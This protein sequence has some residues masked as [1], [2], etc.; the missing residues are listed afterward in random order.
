MKKRKEREKDKRN[1]KKASRNAIIW[2]IK[3]TIVTL[4]LSILIRYI[5]ELGDA[6]IGTSIS[7]VFILLVISIIFDAIGVAATV[8]DISTLNAKASNN[9]YGAKMAVKLAQNGAKVSSICADVIGD[10]CGIISGACSA[11][12]VIKLAMDDPKL[13]IWQIIV[14]GI[15]AALTVGGKAFFKNIA[16]KY[17]S[18]IILILGQILSIFSREERKK[19]FKNK[20]KK[21]DEII[22]EDNSSKQDSETQDI[23]ND[24]DK[25]SEYEKKLEMNRLLKNEL[26]D[27][28][29]KKKKLIKNIEMLECDYL[30]TENKEEINRLKTELANLEKREEEIAI[31][32]K[33]LDIQNLK[34]D[35]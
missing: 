14:S 10:V 35:N 20:K 17:S 7:L 6:S 22:E 3:I 8:C 13:Y 11:A 26:Q 4:V 31:E 18:N 25:K 12:V 5:T 15:L 33:S 19:L 29:Q 24:I 28:K 2:A 32:R 16:I 30:N 27:I 23:E 21:E 1:R 9:K 34:Q